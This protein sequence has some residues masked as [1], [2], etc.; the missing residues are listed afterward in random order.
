[1]NAVDQRQNMDSQVKIQPHDNLAEMAVLGAI[2]IDD[3]AFSRAFDHVRER[4]F[5]HGH[6]RMIYSTM[7]D[8]FDSGSPTDVVTVA[9]K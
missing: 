7:H 3:K 1:M 4:S 2:L 5:Y 6:H 9:N 8:L